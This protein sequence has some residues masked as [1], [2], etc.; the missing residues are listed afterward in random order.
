MRIMGRRH[1]LFLVFWLILVWIPPH[2]AVAGDPADP[3]STVQSLLKAVKVLSE[4]KDEREEA[5]AVKQ[6]S[7]TFDVIGLS[8]ACLRKTWDDLSPA[9]QKNFV[10]LFQ[11]VLEKVAYPKSSKFFKDTDIEVEEVTRENGKAEVLTLVVH[12]EEGEVEVAYCLELL[13]G[14]WLIE[15]ILLDGVSLKLDLR[16]QAQKILREESYEELKRRLQDKLNE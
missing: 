6:I 14:A 5:E 8:K 16:S 1:R 12:P 9:E 3:A 7:G 4:T 2:G 11:E 10:R 13:D 15:D